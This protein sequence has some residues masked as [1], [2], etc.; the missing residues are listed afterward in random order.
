M[1]YPMPSG[2]PDQRPNPTTAGGSEDSTNGTSG[3]GQSGMTPG[4]LAQSVA[5][6]GAGDGG[7]RGS[8]QS[9]QGGMTRD[10][11]QGGPEQA[12]QQQ[13]MQMMEELKMQYEQVITTLSQV[14]EM[15]QQLSATFPA[16][17]EPLAPV[18]EAFTMIG[19]ALVQS[20]MAVIQQ[21]Q[22]EPTMPPQV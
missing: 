16:A 22:A 12:Q 21:L 1:P 15:V 7:G 10:E 19:Q 9:P 18:Q 5:Y 11:V 6:G 3:G 20:M 13:S 8:D 2:A 17:Q 4:G 14:Q